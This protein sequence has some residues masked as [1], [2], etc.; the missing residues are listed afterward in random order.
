MDIRA[1]DILLIENNPGDIR[2]LREAFA[3]CG[4]DDRLEVAIDGVEAIRYLRR[5]APFAITCRPDLILLDLNL[6][7]KDGRKV[8]KGKKW[9][10]TCDGFRS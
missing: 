4:T 6:P 9:M 10:P 3:E 1:I 5:E 2:L 7:K 8:L